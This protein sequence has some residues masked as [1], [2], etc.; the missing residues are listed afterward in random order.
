MFVQLQA[1]GEE[2][3]TFRSFDCQSQ[4]CELT[5]PKS[6]SYTN[7]FDAGQDVPL[8]GS[9]HSL[10]NHLAAG[11]DT[12]S[13]TS[14]GLKPLPAKILYPGRS[15]LPTG[16]R[17]S[18]DGRPPPAPAEGHGLRHLPPKTTIGSPTSTMRSTTLASDEK[19]P[20]THALIR[21]PFL[22][23]SHNKNNR[24]SPPGSIS[25]LSR[26]VSLTGARTSPVGTH[27]Q[28]GTSSSKPTAHG[29]AP[30]GADGTNYRPL[31]SKE[32]PPYTVTAPSIPDTRTALLVS[33][34]PVDAPGIENVPGAVRRPMSFVKAL[35]VSDQLA[36]HDQPSKLRQKAGLQKEVMIEEDEQLYGSSYE[37]AV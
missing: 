8:G 9:A 30:N 15:A 24:H 7:L 35:E 27:Y 19:Y 10:R 37:I 26:I 32:P 29:P 33:S 20:M 12:I 1:S 22:S 28:Y 3:E 17:T 16:F 25:G 4:D 31:L 5:P 13:S 23:S 36:A 11:Q 2:D 18:P 21:D 14:S 6:D 34:A